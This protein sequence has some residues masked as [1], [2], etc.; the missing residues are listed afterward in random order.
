MRI[1][2]TFL[3]TAPLRQVFRETDPSLCQLSFLR[4]FKFFDDILFSFTS[5]AMYRALTFAETT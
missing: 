5:L 2:S 4:N 1:P 3:L